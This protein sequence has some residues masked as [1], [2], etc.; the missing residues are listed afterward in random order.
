MSLITNRKFLKIFKDFISTDEIIQAKSN[1]KYE[2]SKYPY[3]GMGNPD[4]N[5]LFVGSEKAFDP[6]FS[7]NIDLHERILNYIH[8]CDIVN[9]YNHIFND[10]FHPTLL[11]RPYLEGFNPFSPLTL[12]DTLIKV[13]YS[14]KPH[15]YKKMKQIMDVQMM[16]F[17]G[18][19]RTVYLQEVSPQLY[20]F[21]MFRYCFLTDISDLPKPS[22]DFG[23]RFSIKDFMMTNRYSEMLND[24]S[25]GGF[26][27]SF[28]NIVIYAGRKYTGVHGSYE[29]E[30]IIKL[31]NPNIIM[32]AHYTNGYASDIYICPKGGARLIFINQLTSRTFNHN[33]VIEHDLACMDMSDCLNIRNN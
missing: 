7:Y 21:S 6:K 32:N 26:Y 25:L 10:K 30:I 4:S 19:N 33:N 5:L 28:K 18:D 1:K 8:W 9:N 20:D 13:M 23:K 22:Q 11:N 27:R 24:N 31:F 15:T 3:I 29:R 16:Y 17:S 14:G 12:Y 2:P